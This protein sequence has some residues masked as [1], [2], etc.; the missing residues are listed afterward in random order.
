MRVI[1]LVC[2]A[3][4][5]GETLGFGYSNYQLPKLNT[6]RETYYKTTGT[7]IYRSTQ[8]TNK[9]QC[10]ALNNVDPTWK[11]RASPLDTFKP[12][13]DQVLLAYDGDDVLLSAKEPGQ[14]TQSSLY[15]GIVAAV[16]AD[17]VNPNIAEGARVY[18]AQSCTARWTVASWTNIYGSELAPVMAGKFINGIDLNNADGWRFTRPGAD[19]TFPFGGPPQNGATLPSNGFSAGD[20]TTPLINQEYPGFAGSTAPST[21]SGADADVPP[22]NPGQQSNYL[23]CPEASILG[24]ISE[25]NYAPLDSRHYLKPKSI[26]RGQHLPFVYNLNTAITNNNPA[27]AANGASFDLPFNPSLQ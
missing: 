13:S 8:C 14:T 21:L 17:I 11:F 22:E 16:S 4:L 19:T 25:V 2:L 24:I 27:A 7:T 12:L 18:F 5:L 23:L 3:A 10:A 26:N 6:K 20:A 9:L 1:L 15:T